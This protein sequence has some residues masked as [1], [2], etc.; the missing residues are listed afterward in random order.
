MSGHQGASSPVLYPLSQMAGGLIGQLVHKAQ[1]VPDFFGRDGLIMDA[2]AAADGAPGG[3][4]EPCGNLPG[5]FVLPMSGTADGLCGLLTGR[6]FPRRQSQRRCADVRRAA[7]Q[8][9]QPVP[10][11]RQQ[12]E[13]QMQTALTS[14]TAQ[15][16]VERGR[17]GG[18]PED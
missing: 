7:A 1:D 16:I 18:R 11:L 13:P 4:S 14:F 9:G 10:P 12:I 3:L 6:A 15:G 17:H 2:R 8:Q 5:K